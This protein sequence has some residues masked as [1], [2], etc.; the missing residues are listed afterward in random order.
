M[1]SVA[2]ARQPAAKRNAVA[3]CA[4]E[5]EGCK[6]RLPIRPPSHRSPTG[7]ALRVSQRGFLQSAA[8]GARRSAGAGDAGDT[9]LS[10][11]T[12]RRRA[13]VVMA[14]PP[15]MLLPRAA[16]RRDARRYPRVV[17]A[18]RGALPARRAVVIRSARRA[19]LSI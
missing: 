6:V 8:S 13:P 19:S 3:A 7:L 14:S 18:L 4:S 2:R 15:L 1:C 12:G 5:Y 10:R 9:R 17:V 11:M 16:R